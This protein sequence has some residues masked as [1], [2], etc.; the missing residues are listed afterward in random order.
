MGIRR[1]LKKVGKGIGKGI[2]VGGKV[3][4]PF[5]PVP[6]VRDIIL[7]A[8][9]TAEELGGK[10]G[11]L[12]KK[13]ATDIALSLLRAIEAISGRE[14]YDEEKLAQA[15]GPMI[16]AFVTYRNLTQWKK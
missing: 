3:A 9:D 8:I 7:A 10:K 14:L 2:L 11:K 1:K 15:L 13:L 6:M 4:A 16:D 5:I 12:K